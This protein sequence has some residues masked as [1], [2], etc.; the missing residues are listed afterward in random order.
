MDHL[1]DLASAAS[2]SRPYRRR[3]AVRPRRAQKSNSTPLV[4]AIILAA[5]LIGGAIIYWATR[6]P[7][8]STSDSSTLAL[9]ADDGHR[10]TEVATE[11][12]RAETAR[13][14]AFANRLANAL[15]HQ[16][17]A[18]LGPENST[19]DL[20][21]S[22]ACT[23]A[24]THL[25]TRNGATGRPNAF[26]AEFSGTYDGTGE[27]YSSNDTTDL[28]TAFVPADGGK[29]K[30][31]SATERP[32]SHKTSSDFL[33]VPEKGGVQRDISHLDWFN[34]AVDE[35]QKGPAAR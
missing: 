16:R 3:A 1:D 33:G 29:W 15:G 5:V 11:Q 34:A 2:Q 31:E 19:A 7:P 35:A 28:H 22:Y 10:A 26:L 25:G 6:P 21:I 18:V 14:Q 4:V 24:V 32:V 13:F 8:A 12:V 20:V 9:S 30:I 17:K 27:G 23:Y